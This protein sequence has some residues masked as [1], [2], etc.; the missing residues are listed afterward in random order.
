MPVGPAFKYRGGNAYATPRSC[1]KIREIVLMGGAYGTG[2]F[3]PSAEFNI[4]ADPEA[5][6]VV[7]TSGVPLVMMG[8]D[9]T[10]QT[11]CTPDVIARMERAGGPAGE[12]FSDIMNFTLK[13]QFENYGWRPGARR[14][15]HR[16]SD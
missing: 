11:V 6:R 16:L 2:N 7:F 12:L 14:H 4:F 5:A 13:T 1:S 15:L 9:L 10:N 8:L 3:T